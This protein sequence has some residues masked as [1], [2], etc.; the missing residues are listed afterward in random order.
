MNILIAEDNKQLC[1]EI[2][3]FCELNSYNVISVYDGILATEEI[4]KN[5]FDLYIL[6]VNL[7]NMNGL[8][9]VKYIRSTD[10]DTPIIVITASDKLET[11]Q[12]A[13]NYGCTEYIKKPFFLQELEI[14]IRKIITTNIDKCINFSEDFYHNIDENNFYHNGKVIELRYKEKRFIKILMKNMGKTIKNS[15]IYDYVW[16]NQIKDTYPLRQLVAELR[17][18][19]PYEIIITKPKE[20]Y[21]IE[22]TF[23]EN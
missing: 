19:L 15:L 1:K 10:V 20:G 21:L 11:I 22:N 2:T 23:I 17:K 5:N 9:I 8:D 14:R 6:D 12:N 4:E 18:K 3:K 13:Y 16:E 7:P